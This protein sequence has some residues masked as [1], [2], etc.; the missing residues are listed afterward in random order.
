[1]FEAFIQ[2]LALLFVPV[3]L[4]LMALGVI[5]GIIVGI[6][7]G[8]G[9]VLGM[10]LILPFIFG[11]EPEVALPLFVC[12]TAPA[13]SAGSITAIILNIPGETV[14][15]ATLIDGYPM[16]KKGQAGRALGAAFMSSGLGGTIGV[17]L[18]LALIPAVVVIV[19]VMGT[20]E[21]WAMVLVG[22]AFIGVLSAGSIIRGLISGLLGLFI[23][24]IGFQVTTGVSRM[25]FGTAF[26]YGGLGLVPLLLGIFAIPELI[27]IA[28]TGSIARGEMP[29]RIGRELMEGVKDVFRHFWLF[30][31]S[32]VIG[33]I[34]G[35]VPG[36]G[37][38]AATFIAYGQ[39]VKTSKHPERFGT[40][41]VEG[42][43]AP[44][45]ANNAVEG[46]A[47]LPTLAF[48]LPGN[49]PLTILLGAFIVVG[50]V[51][52]PS[53]LMEHLDLCFS[54]LWATALSNIAA[55]I[56]CLIFIRQI[57]KVAYISA[58]YLIP[59]IGVF[60]A[61]GAFAYHEDLWDLVVL[62]AI[63]ALGYFMK[64]FRYS[65]AALCLGFILG[66]TFER[67]LFISLGAYGPGFL[68]RPIVLALLVLCVFITAGDQIRAN[69]GKL[70]KLARG[71]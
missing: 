47:L 27:D 23:S 25:T 33:F 60:V 35:V 18:A 8:V 3:T 34:I 30:L 44:E 37:A 61:A 29:K 21:L 49:A 11:L 14:N 16:T 31:R 17:F 19:K 66:A 65:R 62:S 24:I 5:Y 12:I 50:L 46:G 43:I 69:A 55:I 22:I 41:I 4:G 53:I 71:K 28:K 13:I 68:V 7:P 6:L 38:G 58:V 36:V 57:I 64:R 20:P 67:T 51:P 32:N 42:V 59:I 1:M 26:L 54:L 56:I 39:A 48:G 10:A 40:G 9:A 63:G 15:A 45:S 2:G 70:L 52:G